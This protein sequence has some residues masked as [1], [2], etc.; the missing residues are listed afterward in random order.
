MKAIY[1]YDLTIDDRSEAGKMTGINRVQ[2]PK[3][4]EVLDFQALAHIGLVLFASVNL[5]DKL[6]APK[7]DEETGEIIAPAPIP[8]EERIFE[9]VGTGWPFDDT[10]HAEYI[11]TTQDRNQ[12]VWHC[13]E[14]VEAAK[15]E[16]VSAAKGGKK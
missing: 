7:R 11:G 14:V 2:M 5:P 9:V 4:A 15:E 12:M 8:M 13:F 16:P 6:P 1:K 3:G 10:D